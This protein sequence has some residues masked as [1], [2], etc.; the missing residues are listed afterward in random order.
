MTLL[1]ARRLLSFIIV[2]LAF[3]WVTSSVNAET[4]DE[5]LTRLFTELHDARSKEVAAQIES[6]IQSLWLKSKS[7][8]T[9]LLMQRAAMAIANQDYPVAIEMLDRV[10]TREPDF[11]EG[12]NRRATVFFLMEDF[13]RSISDIA[14][15]LKREPRHFGALSGLGFIL[16]MRG[17]TAHARETYEKVLAIYPLME[18]ARLTIEKIDKE[19]GETS[20]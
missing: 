5:Q 12:W 7:D 11:A 18:S 17:D 15:T 1:N 4:R 10:I 19:K 8:T 14:E 13:N 3:L 6:R 9:D 2:S 20:L 16:L